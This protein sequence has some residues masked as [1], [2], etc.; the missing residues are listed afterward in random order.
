MRT[1]TIISVALSLL[2]SCGLDPNK[3]PSARLYADDG[4]VVTDDN[5]LNFGIVGATRLPISGTGEPDAPMATIADIRSEMPVRDLSFLVLPGGMVARSSTK[6]WTGFA[7]RW[8]P[9]LRSDVISDNQARITALPLPGRGEVSGDKGLKGMNAVF[10]GTG[11]DIGYGRVASWSRIDAEVQ[12]TTWRLIVLDANK[13]GLG[14][15]W[16]E[17]MFWLPGVVSGDDY[18]HLVV[19]LS[20]PRFT[21]AK[22]WKMDGK[23]PQAELLEVIDAHS[24]LLKLKAVFS[25]GPATN[26]VYLPSSEYGE[27]HVV[28]GNGGIAGDTFLRGASGEDAGRDDALTLES[29]FT[30]VLLSEFSGAASG[31][32]LSDKVKEAVQGTEDNPPQFP[33]S[34]F[35]VQGWWTVRLGAKAMSATFRQRTWKG[36][37]RDAYRMTW[38][39]KS[40]WV[41]AAL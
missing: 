6:E 30:R 34:D 31:L 12:G 9:V 37:Y 3:I 38:T 13:D 22:G 16:D 7:E 26:E 21:T 36:E 18:D 29:V 27:L 15:R 11:A 10:D 20:S 2:T 28:V 17:Q 32:E 19:F 35:P 41:A 39:R 25:G 24:D 33:G 40:G 1:L 8:S 5:T 4:A 23:G 14:S